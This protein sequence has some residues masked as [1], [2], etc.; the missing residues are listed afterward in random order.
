MRDFNTA[1]PVRADQQRFGKLLCLP[2]HF[3]ILTD[4]QRLWLRPVPVKHHA[5]DNSAPSVRVCLGWSRG[6]RR[7]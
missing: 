5:A 2:A 7:G 6:L 4:R 3:D 1:G